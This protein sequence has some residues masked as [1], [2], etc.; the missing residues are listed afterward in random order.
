M[1]TIARFLRWVLAAAWLLPA[2]AG[3][4]NINLDQR[5]PRD[6]IS[7]ATRAKGRNAWA[8]KCGYLRSSATQDSLDAEGMYITFTDAMAPTDAEAPCIE[9]LHR[10]GMCNLG[11]F[12]AT[13]RLLFDG[14][15]VTLE[16]AHAAGLTHVTALAAGS[17]PLRLFF[18]EEP[19]AN[20]IS[21]PYDGALVIIRVDDGKTV[22]VTPNHPMVDDTGHIVRADRLEVGMRLLTLDGPRTVVALQ[23]AAY[24]GLV[25]SLKP[26]RAEPMANVNI[27]EGFL[28]GSMRFQDQWADDADRLVRRMDPD[29]DAI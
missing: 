21:G 5:C 12:A 23:S 26:T 10:L 6:A 7:D 16:A 2:A 20:Y 29:A 4:A 3:A 25:W 18:Q 8:L 24:T 22:R 13:E 17:S 9:G 28:T 14:R 19:I 27:A 11:C 15:P 1:R